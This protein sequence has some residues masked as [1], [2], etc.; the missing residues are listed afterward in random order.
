MTVKIIKNC[1]YCGALFEGSPKAKFCTDGHRQA[2]YRLRKKMNNPMYR[3]AY[4]HYTGQSCQREA[5]ADMAMRNG[6]ML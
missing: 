2:A 5:L 1:E 3:N 4:E 6:G